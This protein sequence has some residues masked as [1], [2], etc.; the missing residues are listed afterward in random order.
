MNNGAGYLD[1]FTLDVI[2]EDEINCGYILETNG[3]SSGL[4]RVAR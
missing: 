2:H 1:I 4:E 3:T